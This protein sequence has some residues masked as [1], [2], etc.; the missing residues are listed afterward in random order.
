ML[1]S[2]FEITLMYV[3]AKHNNNGNKTKKNLIIFLNIINLKRKKENTH[4]LPSPPLVHVS[5]LISKSI[6]ISPLITTVKKNKIVSLFFNVR[7]NIFINF[8][9]FIL[10][11]TSLYLCCNIKSF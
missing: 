9:A 5:S 11:P 2:C 7:L 3:D 4:L 1:Y 8:L 6:H 10:T